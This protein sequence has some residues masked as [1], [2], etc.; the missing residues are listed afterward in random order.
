MQPPGDL[1]FQQV[2]DLVESHR[3][4]ISLILDPAETEKNGRPGT[5]IAMWKPGK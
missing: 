3:I 1:S 2:R 4:H 5:A